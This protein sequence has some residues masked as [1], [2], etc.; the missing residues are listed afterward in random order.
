MTWACSIRHADYF[1][2]LEDPREDPRFIT[3]Q[4]IFHIR[5]RQYRDDA[6][7]LYSEWVATHVFPHMNRWARMSRFMDEHEELF[8]SL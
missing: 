2:L 3:L 6:L 1:G 5:R 7:H 8:S 4:R